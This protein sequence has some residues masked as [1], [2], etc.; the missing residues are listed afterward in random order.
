MPLKVVSSYK[1]VNLKV[2]TNTGVQTSTYNPQKAAPVQKTYKPQVT[3][4]PQTTATTKQ[5]QAAKPS[6]DWAYTAGAKLAAQEDARQAAAK[7]ERKRLTDAKNAEITSGKNSWYGKLNNAV[8]KG[9]E[10]QGRELAMQYFNQ[11]ETV[12]GGHIMA[13]QRNYELEGA[14]L[15]DW[16]IQSKSEAEYNERVKYAN[17]WLETQYNEI[18]ADINDFTETQKQLAAYGQTPLSGMASKVLRTGKKIVGDVG[19][20]AWNALT[21]TASQPSRAINT[22]INLGNP[23]RLRMYDDGTE[24]KGGSRNL[25]WAYNASKDQRLLGRGKADEKAQMEWLQK[26]LDRKRASGGTNILGTSTSS[27]FLRNGEFDRLRILYGDDLVN[28]LSDPLNFFTNNWAVKAGEKIKGTKLA[29]SFGNLTKTN[30][31]K[32]FEKAGTNKFITNILISNEARKS[33]PNS[34]RNWIKKPVGTR[35]DDFYHDNKQLIDYR[36]GLKE[37][38]AKRVSDWQQVQKTYFKDT[39]IKLANLTDDQARIFQEYVLPQT[40]ANEKTQKLSKQS[41]SWDYVDLP[42]GFGKADKRA[43]EDLARSLKNSTDQLRAL[44]MDFADQVGDTSRSSK[45]LRFN[46]RSYIP[47]YAKDTPI[48]PYADDNRINTS[49]WYLQRKTSNVKQSAEQLRYSYEKR[50]SS[51]IYPETGAGRWLAF[52]SDKYKQQ[53]SEIDRILELRKAQYSPTQ[54]SRIN[55]I[56]QN[57]KYTPMKIWKKSVLKWNPA[58]YVNNILWNVPASVSAAGAD[59]FLEYGK[60]ITNKNYWKQVYKTLPDGVASNI[61]NEIGKGALATK[62][63]D[64]ARIATFNALKKKG[65]SDDKAL[66]QVN[67]WLFDYGTKNWE[68]PIKGIL[69]FWHWQKNI[70]RLGATMA[71]QSPRSAKVYSEGYKQFFERPL[72]SLPNEDQVYT[73]PE[74]GQEVT[75]NPREAYKGK[76]KIG[77]KW[78]GVPS[79]AVNPETALQFGINPYL[80]AAA[81]LADSK[82][83][84]GERNTDRKAWTVLADRFPAI[85]LG[86]AAVNRNNKDIEFWFSQSGNSKWAQGWD[87][88]KSNYKQGLDNNRKFYNTLKSFV[89]MPRGVEFDETE[90]NLKKNLTNFNKE[91]FAIDWAAKEDVDYKAAQKEKEELAKKY[92]FDLQSDIYDNYWSKYDTETTRNTKALKK[93]AAKFN[94][95]DSGY[96]ADYFKLPAGSRTQASARRPFLIGKFDEWKRDHTF[97]NN[98]Y[99]KLPNKGEINPFTLKRQE[100]DSQARRKAGKAK[101]QRYLEYQKAKASGDWSWFEKNGSTKRARQSTPYTFDGKFFKSEESMNRYKVGAAWQEYFKLDSLAEKK[102]FLAAHPELPQYETPTTAEGWTELRKT[103]RSKTRERAR[104]L[105]GFDANRELLIAEIKKGLPVKSARTKRI[106]YKF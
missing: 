56:T 60:L 35:T 7:V 4:K 65:F 91:F 23:N 46:N 16:V 20:K 103:L 89:G 87:N 31:D 81:D 90:F 106:K 28:L 102:A 104:K 8:L 64:V 62:I 53:I 93:D 54:L 22:A 37:E 61:S 33:N 74:T 97:A 43:L 24:L 71:F 19:G 52:N 58:W 39:Q 75:Y 10:R 88:D 83:R 47:N 6:M 77:N 26:T 84:F 25:Q 32:V 100:S 63:E 42:R 66:K 73:D 96:W 98:P 1:P 17:S 68:R 30:I 67:N 76:A 95:P 105:S 13:K 48:K 80:S 27:G 29:K 69:P 11:N 94:S 12:W 59:V 3:A 14:R 49:S 50:I 55:E 5:V 45:I 86:R 15:N 72:N 41:F 21:W 9:N 57:F 82:N 79:F 2:T 44:G 18:T 70:I 51:Q 99:Y 85:N 36:N 78:Y 101:Y 92:G 40:F 34:I 38:F